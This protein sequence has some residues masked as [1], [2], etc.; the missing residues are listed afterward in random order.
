MAEMPVS[1]NSEGCSRRTG[2]IAEPVIGRIASGITA[3][4]PSIGRP[5]PLKLR[6][7]IC[8]ETGSRATS[9]LKITSARAGL[10]PCVSSSTWIT[11]RASDDLDDLAATLLAAVEAD[12]D[13]LAEPGAP[14]PFHEEQRPGDGGGRA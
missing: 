12:A 14:R 2:L 9:P 3:G 8:R 6:P 13:H 10:I 4:R 5:I 11:A 7:S 1:M